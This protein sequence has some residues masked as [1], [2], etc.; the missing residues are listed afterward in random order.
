MKNLINSFA[1]PLKR[2]HAIASFFNLIAIPQD[3]DIPREVAVSN[4]C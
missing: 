2:N 1:L 3:F 4:P